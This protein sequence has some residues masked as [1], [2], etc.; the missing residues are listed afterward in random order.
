[1]PD[2]VAHSTDSAWRRA[3]AGVVRTKGYAAA[4]YLT[5]FA[6]GCPLG[7]AVKAAEQQ[8]SL[9]LATAD[10]TK[11]CSL[12]TSDA[13]YEC[14]STPYRQF[15]I[16]KRPRSRESL[17]EMLAERRM[18]IY[19]GEQRGVRKGDVV[20]DCGSNIGTF[21]AEALDAGASRI[22]AC[23]PSPA[24]VECIQ[25]TFTGELSAGRVILYPKG[26]W[27]ETTVLRLSPGESPAGDSFL[28]ESVNGME[29][30]V[31]TIDALVSELALERVDFIKMD[32]EGAERNA[33]Q[34]ARASISRF[35]PRLA[36]SAYHLPDDP[37]VLKHEVRNAF[38]GYKPHC[39]HARLEVRGV[40]HA[41]IAPLVYF[42]QT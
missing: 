17:F 27:H 3:K 36:V 14:W 2:N 41:R 4:L 22:V 5:G 23:E 32:I 34:G 33:L 37:E 7:L 16:P 42:F 24:N 12:V 21:V 31:T 9:D 6:S 35:R 40:L 20:I 39:D 19:G 26:L 15:W 38:A 8:R 18:N 28:R 25:R 11:H 29:L 10:L 30:P 1:M 13:G